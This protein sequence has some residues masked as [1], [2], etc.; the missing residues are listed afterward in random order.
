MGT[1]AHR[2]GGDMNEAAFRASYDAARRAVKFLGVVATPSTL[3][4]RDG[5]RLCG[6]KQA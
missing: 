2:D 1:R 3:L 4:G 6:T 5:L